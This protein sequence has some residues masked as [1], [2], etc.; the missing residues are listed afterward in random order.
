MEKQKRLENEANNRKLNADDLVK[1]VRAKFNEAGVPDILSFCIRPEEYSW[2]VLRADSLNMVELY[3]NSHVA[4]IAFK[5]HAGVPNP[6][7]LTD[8]MAYTIE[9]PLI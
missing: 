9:T 8:A 4:V 1:R 5:R 7:K 6:P 3:S 2:S